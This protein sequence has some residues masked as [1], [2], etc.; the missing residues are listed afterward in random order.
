MVSEN[1]LEEKEDV[2]PEHRKSH[3]HESVSISGG[4]VCPTHI[5][6]KNHLSIKTEELQ[7]FCNFW[8]ISFGCY[9]RVFELEF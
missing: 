9:F 3:A 1:F 2:V 8:L 7:L 6:F 5:N 4:K